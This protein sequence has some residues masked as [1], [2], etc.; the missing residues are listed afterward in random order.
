M[1]QQVS[2]T[3]PLLWHD[4]GELA[5][6]VA[7]PA[8]TVAAKARMGSDFCIMM[9]GCGLFWCVELWGSNVEYDCQASNEMVALDGSAFDSQQREDGTYIHISIPSL[10]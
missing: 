4:N 7:P 1:K 5:G 9:G 6:Q 8:M 3:G 2:D 10:D